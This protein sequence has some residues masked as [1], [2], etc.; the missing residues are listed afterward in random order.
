MPLS[1]RRRVLSVLV[2]AALPLVAALVGV[3]AVA[4]ASAAVAPAPVVF[5]PAHAQLL[6]T[7]PEDGSTV[8]SATE[9]VLSFNEEVNP[10]FVKVVVKGP[11]GNEVVADP[12]VDGREVTQPLASDLPAG[13][14]E[15]A[16][17]VVSTDGHPV[18]GT[19]EFT[20]T[21]TPTPSTSSSPSPTASLSSTPTASADA[22]QGPSPTV[23]ASP[24]TDATDDSAPSTALWVALGALAIAVLSRSSNLPT[25]FI[26][27]EL[28]FS[29]SK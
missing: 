4:R 10:D 23:T 8:K 18:A 27:W 24:A 12:V 25:T 15:V 6:A 26:V 29:K 9:V 13:T 16:Y 3:G 28:Q 11:Q 1:R 5:L 2:V 14:H 7:F 20:T 21:L 19:I 22:S 17:R